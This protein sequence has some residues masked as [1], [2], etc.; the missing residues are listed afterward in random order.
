[1]FSHSHYVSGGSGTLG[2]GGRVMIAAGQ[3]SDSALTSYGGAITMTSG[4]ASSSSSG[5]ILVQASNAF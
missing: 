2:T 1:M 4:Y 5:S 3:T